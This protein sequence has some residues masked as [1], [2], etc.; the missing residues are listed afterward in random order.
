[1]SEAKPEFPGGL[2]GWV[3]ILVMLSSA[4]SLSLMFTA[5]GPILPMIAD[6]FAPKG[7]FVRIPLLGAALDGAFFAQ[8]MQA[9]PSFGLMLG[10][11]PVGF[12]IDRFGAR[13]VLIGAALVFTALGSAGLYIESAVLLLASRFL[14]GFAAIGF[15]A[16]TVWLIGARFGDVD[17]ARWLSIRNM[18]GGVAGLVA[19]TASGLLAQHYDWHAPFALFLAVL[20]IIP[21]ALF[22]IPASPRVDTARSSASWAEL[23]PMWPLY[24]LIVVLAVVMMM[25][26][27]QLPFLLAA[28]GITGAAG[29]SHIMLVGSTMTIAGSLVYAVAVTRFSATRT[30]SLIAGFI[31]LG[32]LTIGLSWAP[33]VTAVGGALSGFGS[34]LLIPHF[35]RLVLGRVSA[36]VRGSAIGFAFAAIYFGDLLNPFLIHPITLFVGIHQTFIAIGSLTLA[37]ALQIFIPRGAGAGSA[38]VGEQ[39]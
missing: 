34:G 7:T 18:A 33:I 20:A 2:R 28:D 22:A 26:S 4:P 35:I 25:N 36:S 19:I 23:E 29:R 32:I 24:L 5:T 30:Y 27:T 39:G 13:R 12:A 8:L 6:H 3:A 9:L 14:L 10:S 31:G 37:S 38:P 11:I 21:L 16:A 15:G 17:R 1:M